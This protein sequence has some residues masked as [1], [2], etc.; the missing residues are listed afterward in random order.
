MTKRKRINWETTALD[1]DVIECII[2]RA[3]RDIEDYHNFVN[4]RTNAIMDITATHLN[5]CP[6]KLRDLLRADDFNFKHDIIG[7]HNHINR[8]TG[9]L[10]DFFLPR[11]AQLEKKKKAREK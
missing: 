11:T 4:S 3:E 5:G 1:R 9:K 7:I 10:E 6:L 8:R 2:T